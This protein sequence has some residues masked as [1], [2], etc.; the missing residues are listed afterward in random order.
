MENPC[1]KPSVLDP[2][3]VLDDGIESKSGK[4][5]KD[6]SEIQNVKPQKMETL[7][8]TNLDEDIL[9]ELECVKSDC[10]KMCTN[11]KSNPVTGV[12]NELRHERVN[13]L[14]S[15]PELKPQSH[16]DCDH[17]DQTT[18]SADSGHGSSCHD[19]ECGS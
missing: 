7:L 12:P 2:N 13:G 15:V 1:E 3:S 6:I 5:Q 8:Q 19:C 9:S 10:V 18:E 11:I 17:S 4:C 16:E 14:V